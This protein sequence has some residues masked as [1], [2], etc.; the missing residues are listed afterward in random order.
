MFQAVNWYCS[1]RC[2]VLQNYWNSQTYNITSLRLDLHVISSEISLLFALICIIHESNIQWRENRKK[3]TN[4]MNLRIFIS[5]RDV[6]FLVARK[7]LVVCLALFST[8]VHMLVQYLLLVKRIR[9]STVCWK[10]TDTNLQVEIL[11]P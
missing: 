3:M 11:F 6:L 1:V 10:W 7:L 5:G 4:L 8:L 9:V 2:K